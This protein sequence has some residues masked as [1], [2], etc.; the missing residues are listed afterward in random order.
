MTV[1]MGKI[2]NLDSDNGD[3]FHN[4]DGTDDEEDYKGK[5]VRKRYPKFQLIYGHE[6]S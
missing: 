4:L 6:G 2:T 3:E 5:F 1:T